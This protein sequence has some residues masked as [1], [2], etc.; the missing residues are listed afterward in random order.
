VS[1]HKRMFLLASL[2]GLL[3]KESGL[4]RHFDP[5]GDCDG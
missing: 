5:S 1:V 4:R 3:P 2:V